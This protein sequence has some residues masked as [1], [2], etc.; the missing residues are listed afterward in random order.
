MKTN[1]TIKY[2]LMVIMCTTIFGCIGG[3]A[4]SSTDTPYVNI[5]PKDGKPID[6]S[7]KFRHNVDISGDKRKK[8]T[9]HQATLEANNHISNIQRRGIKPLVNCPVCMTPDGPK[10]GNY[11]YHTSYEGSHDILIPEH[12]RGTRCDND[13]TTEEVDAFYGF[14]PESELPKQTIEEFNKYNYFGDKTVFDYAESIY[15]YNGYVITDYRKAGFE[16]ITD[17]MTYFLERKLFNTPEGDVIVSRRTEDEGYRTDI[18]DGITT[19][20]KL[21]YEDYDLHFTNYDNLVGTGAL[22]R[23]IPLYL[24]SATSNIGYVVLDPESFVMSRKFGVHRK[25][26]Q[27]D[28]YAYIIDNVLKMKPEHRAEFYEK[29]EQQKKAQVDILSEI[30][31]L[32]ILTEINKSRGRL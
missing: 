4:G 13:A 5:S 30:K 17:Y 11:T 2:V 8:M 19:K 3:E 24:H 12:D 28:R 15:L 20:E 22:Y 14:K 10:P 32:Y 31:A 6:T 7:V 9:D 29:L 25:G 27:Y 21:L 18:R 23:D 1:R 16:V 26:L